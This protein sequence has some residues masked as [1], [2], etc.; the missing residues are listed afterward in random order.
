MYKYIW[1]PLQ[2]HQNDHYLYIGI[3]I[4]SQFKTHSK[5]LK[6]C[7]ICVSQM[8]FTEHIYTVLSRWGAP[9]NLISRHEDQ[10]ILQFRL[11]MFVARKR[12]GILLRHC[13]HRV[14]RTAGWRGI[15]NPALLPIVH[16]PSII[17]PHTSRGFSPLGRRFHINIRRIDIITPV[18]KLPS[19][20]IT[21]AGVAVV[22]TVSTERGRSKITVVISTLYGK[23]MGPRDR[24]G[25]NL[26]TK[27]RSRS[28][29]YTTTIP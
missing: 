4:H 22:V 7:A 25:H 13:W 14:Q 20:T 6:E 18:I 28:R 27:S 8:R 26:L 12:T 21:V 15:T 23:A 1:F 17:F 11:F 2:K 5:I 3:K 10:I 29:S 16:Y 24:H 9:L 19:K